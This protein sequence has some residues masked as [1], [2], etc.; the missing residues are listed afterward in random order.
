MKG[1]LDVPRN[2]NGDPM[3]NPALAEYEKKMFNPNDQPE[4]FGVMIAS[5]FLQMDL[6][7]DAGIDFTAN[8]MRGKTPKQ[9]RKL[10]SIPMDWSPEEIEELKTKYPFLKNS[11]VFDPVD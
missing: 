2:A 6:L 3:D 10:F 7:T 5:D 9:I 8:M 4:L 11:D 1:W